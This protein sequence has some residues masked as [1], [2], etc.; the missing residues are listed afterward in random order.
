MEVPMETAS[1]LWSLVGVPGRVF[2]SRR[3]S[4]LFPSRLLARG[5]EPPT[6]KTVKQADNPGVSQSVSHSTGL[7]NATE[8]RGSST[9]H[10]VCPGVSSMHVYPVPQ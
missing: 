1:L 7:R 2:R 9:R 6:G 8:P 4:F 5:R 3:L 10:H